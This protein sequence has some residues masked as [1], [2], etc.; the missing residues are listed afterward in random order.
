MC[1]STPMTSPESNNLSAELESLCEDELEKTNRETL[2]L[3]GGFAPLHLY[4]FTGQKNPELSIPYKFVVPPIKGMGEE[5]RLSSPIQQHKGDP[6]IDT[7]TPFTPPETLSNIIS[8]ESKF[9]ESEILEGKEYD[10]GNKR[11]ILTPRSKIKMFREKIGKLITRP[12]ARIC[13]AENTHKATVILD[14]D[15]TMISN[16]ENTQRVR[17]AI[18]WRIPGLMHTQ[19]GIYFL[20]RPG[21]QEFLHKLQS[22]AEIVVFTASC[23]SYG[24]EICTVLQNVYSIQFAAIC[25]NLNCHLL[26]SKG[27]IKD[28]DVIENRDPQNILIIDDLRKIWPFHQKNVL[29]IVPYKGSLYDIELEN[30]YPR[31]VAFVNNVYLKNGI[32]SK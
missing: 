5:M 2:I 29:Q 30:I 32:E 20:C 4:R 25:T 16:L 26:G 28:L 31:V 3:K 23:P 15:E 21:L 10:K 13:L 12:G 24:L 11:D 22:L 9:E 19:E 6:V 1:K 27:A 7:M 17:S 8:F 18:V 14:L